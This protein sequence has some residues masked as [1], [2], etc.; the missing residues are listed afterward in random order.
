MII[1]EELRKD[2][3]EELTTLM[4]NF[5]NSATTLSNENRNDE[6]I[7]ENIKI[8]ICKIFSTVFNVSY[9]QSCINKTSEN[10]E[11]KNLFNNYIDFF[12]KL[13][14]SWKEKLIKDEEFGMIDEYYKEKV[15]LETANEI[16]QIF[17][18]CFNKYYKE[19]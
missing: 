13:P 14:K 17:I 12:N 5:K 8:N 3:L 4:T 7:L 19:N 2:Y 16:K 10:I 15:K 1:I 6:A 18:N 9:K 11:L